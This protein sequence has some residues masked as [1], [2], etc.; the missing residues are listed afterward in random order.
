MTK[1]EM[2]ADRIYIIE[3]TGK[4]TPFELMY[5]YEVYANGSSSYLLAVEHKGKANGFF[6]RD[7]PLEYCSCQT[8]HKKNNQYLRFRHHE[9]SAEEISN[10]EDIICFGSI[11]EIY[12]LYTCKT[13]KGYNSGYCFEKAVYA[14]YG[15]SEQWAQ[16]NKASNKGG[17]ICL[18]GEE[19][20]IKFVEKGSL[21]TITSTAK[22]IRLID[23]ALK[24]LD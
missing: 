12:S 16:D 18:N 14:K 21:A 11:E 3:N 22:L 6:T 10:R 15:M 1:A 7:I 24:A 8:D 23:K 9:W 13:K 2:I 17:D 4:L 5:F 19:I 20:Q